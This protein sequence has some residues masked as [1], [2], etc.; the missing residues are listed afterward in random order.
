MLKMTRVKLQWSIL[1][2]NKITSPFTIRVFLFQL[3]LDCNQAITFHPDI[4]INM[5]SC[6]L[7]P[8]NNAITSA[9]K[10]DDTLSPFVTAESRGVHWLG[11]AGSCIFW[12]QPKHFGLVKLQPKLN[13]K[14]HEPKHLW[15]GL[16]RVGL[17]WVV[18]LCFF[19]LISL[20]V[21]GYVFFSIYFFFS[22]FVSHYLLQFVYQNFK[23]L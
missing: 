3:F 16:D 9:W 19:S 10:G 2:I 7:Q 14:I 18:G 8:N 4:L 5:F 6:H 23:I 12:T 21:S 1:N 20:V 22:Y 15:V 17:S 11:W 13:V